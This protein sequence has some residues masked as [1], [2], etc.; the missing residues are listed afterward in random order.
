[1]GA[2]LRAT[3]LSD[4][5]LEFERETLVGTTKEAQTASLSVHARFD[6]AY[7]GGEP[8][9]Q[10]F[11][12][13]HFYLGVDGVANPSM[14]Y[15]LSIGPSREFSSTLIPQMVPTEAFFKITSVAVS[16][17]SEKPSLG[18]Q[19][20][21]FSPALNPWWTPDLGDLWIPEFFVGQRQLLLTR[22]IGVELSANP[23]PD[24]LQVTAGFF[25]GNGVFGFNTN[26]SRAVT[27]FTRFQVPI[28]E[29]RLSVGGGGFNFIQGSAGSTNYRSHWIANPFINAEWEPMS[30]SATI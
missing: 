22:D 4:E 11:S 20:G 18:V 21:M 23:I 28:G 17:I 25:N 3:P 12:I 19:L 2:S 15:R 27:L 29:W 14:T 1:M 8:T 30:L 7:S 24:R 6:A 13:P 9:V 16:E 26:N 10:G 5:D